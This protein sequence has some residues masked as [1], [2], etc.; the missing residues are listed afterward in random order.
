MFKRIGSKT[1]DAVKTKAYTNDKLFFFNL[2]PYREELI[3]K[4]KN[5]AV[6][7]FGM[8][9]MAALVLGYYTDSYVAGLIQIQNNNLSYLKTVDAS[10]L[11]KVKNIVDLRK[12]RA[13]IENK[14]QLIGI[15]QDKRSV[16][17]KIF[18]S[19]L[20]DTPPNVF[21][22]QFKLTGD[23]ANITG[24]AAGNNKVALYMQN[25]EKSV[26]FTDPIL[27][28]VSKATLSNNSAVSFNL[29]VSLKSIVVQHK[30]KGVVK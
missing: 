11:K 28:V 14:D 22:T 8:T 9:I 1:K 4:Q 21:L 26:V 2:V 12:E 17:V 13:K 15:L 25:L 29:Q 10:L 20:K 23:T 3:K 6:L 24:Y 18:N 19:L 5:M 16:S 27:N 7:V 30:I